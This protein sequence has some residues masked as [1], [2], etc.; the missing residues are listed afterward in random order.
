MNDKSPMRNEAF[1]E[2]SFPKTLE[3]FPIREYY[4]SLQLTFLDSEL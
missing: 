3:Y 2:A 4:E 1:V